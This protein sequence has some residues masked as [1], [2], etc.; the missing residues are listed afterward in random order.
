MER[1]KTGLA[2][3]KYAPLHA[4]HRHVIETARREMDRVIV[5]VYDAP[6]VTR[7]PLSVRAGWVRALY[8]DVDVIEAIDGPEET[9]YTLPIMDAQ[10]RFLGSLLGGT[11]IDAFYSSEPYGDHVSRY[12]GCTNRQVDP[13]R[14]TN[15]VSGSA[16]RTDLHAH[17]DALDPVVRADVMPRIVLLGGPST[18]KS[19]TA[20]ALAARIG[21][22][23]CAEYGRDYW[24]AH[25]RYHRLSMADL[26]TIA[27]EQ[28]RLERRVA[29][30]ARR[31]VVADTS[32]L[33]TL[34][35]ARYY[36]DRTSKELERIA[37]EYHAYGRLVV[38][39]DT[40][41]PFDDSPDRSGPASRE[42]IQ[43]LTVEELAA[44]E[45]E[46]HVVSGTVDERV[47]RI[48]S[49]AQQWRYAW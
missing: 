43:A 16:V 39:C 48:E 35:Y 26:E 8:P 15:A 21:E 1:V 44:C 31:W 25:Q 24:F 47:G 41:I 20:E 18:G 11:K 46:Y 7:I 36:Y 13:D 37:S 38:L 29:R 17:L 45:L 22:P 33:T 23:V 30:Q 5:I 4:G 40:D 6:S 9:G 19:T 27:R 28:V 42:R 34:V 32:P 3:G 10:E 12:L 2:L 14:T 49:I